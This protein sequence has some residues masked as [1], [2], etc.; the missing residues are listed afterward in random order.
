MSNAPNIRQIQMDLE[1]LATDPALAQ[2]LPTLKNL[3]NALAAGLYPPEIVVGFIDLFRQMRNDIHAGRPLAALLDLTC[4]GIYIQP[5]WQVRDVYQSQ[6]H[7][8]NI[9][10]GTARQ[11]LEEPELGIPI[12]IV[13]L[14]M[15]KEQAQELIS[16]I[17]FDSYPST[18]RDDFAVL[19]TL[20][21]DC[22]IDN[23]H[24][25]YGRNPQDWRPF[26]DTN[27]SFGEITKSVLDRI[28]GYNKPL[29]PVYYQIEQV[30]TDRVLLRKLR[31]YG[32][33]VVMD[34]ISMHHPII[35]LAF[36][37]SLLDAY[38][39][40][41][42]AR[43]A[44]DARVLQVEQRLLA[45]TENSRALEFF[46][47]FHFDLDAKCTEAAQHKDFLRWLIDKMPAVL[48]ESERS[49]SS[50]RSLW[51]RPYKP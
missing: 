37:H 19:C 14:V 29:I 16:A 13:L 35:Q 45:F 48:P 8:F 23:W 28:E 5:D 32:C 12:P 33:L 25:A 1:Q 22:A 4:A 46:Q 26:R 31:L 7:I 24:H 43:I 2:L 44:P 9:I 10:L 18:V 30:M 6:G 3:Q 27:A 38:P 40:T 34:T 42:V 36:R 11:Q 51:F 17:A 50:S 49:T 21:Q 47:R 39:N 20:L 41:L 15:D